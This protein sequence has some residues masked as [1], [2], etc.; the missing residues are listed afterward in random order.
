MLAE[1]GLILTFITASWYIDSGISTLV[2]SCVYLGYVFW[3]RR[4]LK[5]LVYLGL[6]KIKNR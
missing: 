1:W 2:Y 4:D 3:K 5:A 6:D